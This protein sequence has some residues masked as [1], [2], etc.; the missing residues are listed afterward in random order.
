[1]SLFSFM[2]HDEEVPK[3]KQIQDIELDV[4]FES[5]E[6]KGNENENI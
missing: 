2:R 5:G 4:D 3:I 1:M 6:L